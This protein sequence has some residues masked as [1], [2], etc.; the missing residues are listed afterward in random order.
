M[1]YLSI[2]IPYHLKK[3]PAT[4]CR[5]FLCGHS[6]FRKNGCTTLKTNNLGWPPNSQHQH[7][8]CFGKG[9]Q[10]LHLPLLLE[11]GTTQKM[12]PPKVILNMIFLSNSGIFVSQKRD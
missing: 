3:W 7:Y 9:F 12:T 10:P 4:C 8:C 5:S 2:D 11:K 1:E 6:P